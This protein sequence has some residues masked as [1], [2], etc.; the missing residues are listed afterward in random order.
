MRKEIEV[1]LK[2]IKELMAAMGRTGT[3]RVTLKKENFELD[4]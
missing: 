3:K 4:H 1:E 2:Q